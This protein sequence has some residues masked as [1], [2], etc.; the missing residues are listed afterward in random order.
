ML[1]ACAT[2]S[3]AGRCRSGPGRRIHGLRLAQEVCRL[4]FERHGNDIQALVE[5]V[6]ATY[7]NRLGMRRAEEILW[8]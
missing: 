1:R 5:A 7:E 2:G 6:D 8:D 3:R 4:A